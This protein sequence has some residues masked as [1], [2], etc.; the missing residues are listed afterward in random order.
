MKNI[1]T[2]KECDMIIQKYKDDTCYFG[3]NGGMTFNDMYTM[4]RYHMK[5]GQAETMVIIAS[6]IKCGGKI[7]AEEEEN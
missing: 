5:F 1:W 3:E 7:T 2:K 4:L 6:L